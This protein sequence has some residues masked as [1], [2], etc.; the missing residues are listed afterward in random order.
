MHIPTCFDGRRRNGF[1]NVIC[2]LQYQ[3]ACLSFANTRT[4]I[5]H[6][7][8]FTN[9]KYIIQ[10]AILSCHV[11][12]QTSFLNNR[13][14]KNSSS[15]LKFCCGLLTFVIISQIISHK[16]TLLGTMHFSIRICIV[17]KKKCHFVGKEVEMQTKTSKIVADLIPD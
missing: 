10:L 4:I 8:W 15:N 2:R 1:Y 17:L 16:I 5:F 3:E 9:S 13:G 14:M 11:D 7:C 6:V 12:L